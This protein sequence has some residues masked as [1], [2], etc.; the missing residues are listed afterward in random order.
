MQVKSPLKEILPPKKLKNEILEN[1]IK[2]GRDFLL[3]KSH[4]I[5]I[6]TSRVS[7][8]RMSAPRQI[9]SDPSCNTVACFTVLVSECTKTF[10]TLQSNL[11]SDYF[12]RI[13][14]M[15]TS[16]FKLLNISPLD[17]YTNTIYATK[18]SVWKKK[19]ENSSKENKPEKLE[20]LLQNGVQ[21][22]KY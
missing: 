12:K 19:R 7:V 11:D 22:Q 5:A 20:D 18:P 9:I 17:L 6:P 10:K 15:T 14:S 13:K 2:D 4:I 21:R 16:K 1:I 3:K 8:F